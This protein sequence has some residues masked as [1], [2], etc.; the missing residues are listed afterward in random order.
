M[1]DWYWCSIVGLDRPE[2]LRLVGV[3][4]VRDSSVRPEWAPLVEHIVNA[5]TAVW[6]VPAEFGD[7]PAEWAEQIIFDR[8]R[9]EVLEKEW[10]GAGCTTI[11]EWEARP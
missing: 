8:D 6:Q 5:Q 3:A 10:I 11:A 9:I 7:P 4:I 2:G 1:S